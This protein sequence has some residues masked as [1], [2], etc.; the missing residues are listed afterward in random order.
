MK[1][2]FG[3][4]LA[5]AGLGASLALLFAPKKGED[6]RKNKKLMILILIKTNKNKDLNN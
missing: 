2:G 1:R 3:K 6:L 5:G 4:L